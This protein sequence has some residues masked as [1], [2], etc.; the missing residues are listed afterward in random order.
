MLKHFTHPQINNQN[1]TP[2][3]FMSERTKTVQGLGL[4]GFRRNSSGNRVEF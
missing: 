2:D 3:L 4:R 1:I